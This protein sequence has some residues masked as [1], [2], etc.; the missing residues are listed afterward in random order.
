MLTVGE[1]V[2]RPRQALAAEQR[3][4][5]PL[6]VFRPALSV[7]LPLDRA[8]IGLVAQVVDDPYRLVD[9]P[10]PVRR[11]VAARGIVVRGQCCVEVLAYF[12]RRFSVVV[13]SVL[14][15]E[16]PEPLVVNALERVSWW[17]QVGD[18]HDD[19][20][21]CRR[22]LL[23]L[24]ADGEHL[25]KNLLMGWQKVQRCA[26]CLLDPVPWNIAALFGPPNFPV[27]VITTSE[28]SVGSVPNTPPG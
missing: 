5:A 8:F 2:T 22:L 17:W 1:V 11:V 9:D 27:D 12:A 4:Q 3:P 18:R 16:G 15:H 26:D 28:Y 14:A 19:E 6:L 25:I 13:V 24:P 7:D 23:Q 20:P 21:H 10:S